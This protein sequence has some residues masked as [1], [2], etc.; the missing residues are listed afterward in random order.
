MSLFPL[1]ISATSYAASRAASG[2]SSPLYCCSPRVCPLAWA[3]LVSEAEGNARAAEILRKS[4]FHT[5]PQVRR[6]LTCPNAPVRDTK[7]YLRARQVAID[8]ERDARAAETLRKLD[9]TVRAQDRQVRYG[10]HESAIVDGV[11]NRVPVSKYGFW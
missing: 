7:A 8:A 11:R 4:D 10:V 2:N 9:A 3:A 6:E 5:P 1:V